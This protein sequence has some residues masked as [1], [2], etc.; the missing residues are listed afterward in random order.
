[1]TIVPR[2]APLLALGRTPSPPLIPGFA[3]SLKWARRSATDCSGAAPVR[4][5]IRLGLQH[6]RTVTDLP[7]KSNSEQR[8][9]FAVALSASKGDLD[10]LATPSGP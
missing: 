1:M 4:D 2:T 8:R 9:R 7:V 3:Q 6:H 10:H 5:V